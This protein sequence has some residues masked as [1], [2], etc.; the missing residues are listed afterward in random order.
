[1]NN[2]LVNIFIKR[3]FLVLLILISYTFSFSQQDST[4]SILVQQEQQHS[5]RK[6]T[7]YSAVL[8]GLGQYYNKR[9]WKIP[10]VY[11]AIGGC[12]YT[13]IWNNKEYRNYREE[14]VYRSNNTG[15]FSNLDLTKYSNDNL[16]ELSDYHR[17]WRDNFYIFTGLAHLLNIVDANVDAHFFNFDVSEDLSLN[18]R[19]YSYSVEIDKPIMG[20]SLRL[21]FK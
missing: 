13:A 7:I 17:K 1:M 6:A 8:P 12:L 20:L 14:L 2:N 5:P 16:L 11:A 18:I 3:S 21:N 9:Y 4:Q 10:L 19:P 15:L